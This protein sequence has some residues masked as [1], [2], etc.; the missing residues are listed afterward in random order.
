VLAG[1]WAATTIAVVSAALLAL[2]DVPE[3]GWAGA[4]LG[5]LVL[6]PVFGATN[7]L[8]AGLALLVVTAWL[9]RR[10]APVWVASL[11]VVF[12]RV[13]PGWAMAALLSGFVGKRRWLLT[14]VMPFLLAAQ[15]WIVAEAA[16][17]VW[18]SR[19]AGRVP[20]AA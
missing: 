16:V 14:G 3:K 6:W 19:R 9:V 1:R 7:Q 4:G 20:A 15:V 11:A 10:K 12:L 18:R 13:M 2:S 8:L 17:L 5:G